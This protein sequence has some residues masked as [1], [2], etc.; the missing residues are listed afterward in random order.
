MTALE[1]AL[2]HLRRHRGLARVGSFAPTGDWAVVDIDVPVSLPSRARASGRSASGVRN[3]ETCWLWFGPRWPMTAPLVRLRE[4]FPLNLPHINP[5]RAGEQVAPCLFEGDIGEVL[6]RFG[7]DA[8][9]DQLIDWLDKAAADA[10]I[11]LRQG[12]EP[13]RRDACPSSV[14]FSAEALVDVTPRDGTILPLAATFLALDDHLQSRVAPPFVSSENVVFGQT[15]HKN[16][17]FNWILGD[18]AT[19]VAR[20]ADRDGLPYIVGTY[21]PETVHDLPTLLDRAQAVG[22]DAEALAGRLQAYFARSVLQASTDPASWKDGVLA[23][24]I[25][26]V[27]RPAPLVGSSGRTAEVL[28]YAVRLHYDSAGPMVPRTEAHAAHHRHAL[29]PALLSQTSGL[30]GTTTALP[31]VFLGCGSLGSKVALHLGRAGFG[32]VALVDNDT[33]QPH[34]SARHALVEAQAIV[35]APR[36]ADLMATAFARLSHAGAKAFHH[37]AVD[38]LHSAPLF[39]SI[40]PANTVLL[41]DATASLTVLAAETLSASLDASDA[42]LFRIALYGQGHCA[43]GLL[44]S[45]ARAVRV[46]DLAAA[47]FDRCRSDDALRACMAGTSTEPTSLFIGDNCRSLTFP[48]ADSTVSRAAALFSAQIEEWL[49]KELPAN[50]QLCVGQADETGLG[51]RWQRWPIEPSVVLRVDADDG[52]TIRVL[53]SVAKSIASEVSQWLPRETG[54]ALLGRA[55]YTNRTIT[56]AG[57]VD[58]PSDSVRD[59][60]RFVLGVHGLHAALRTAHERSLGYLMFVGTWHSHPMGGSHSGIDRDTLH[61]IAQDAVGLPVVSLVWRPEGLTC[62]VDRW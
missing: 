35:N 12:W 26:V 2:H 9:V 20:A 15:Q 43:V 60:S 59:A 53:G 6:H 4:D 16:E 32:N 24:V 5:H 17:S 19:F 44:E 10:L 41:I 48:M 3:V 61:R 56:I 25:L 1:D 22:V 40:V 21:Q 8:I 50:A 31:L 58:A 29:S 54:G 45:A 62:E 46:D 28:P 11:D 18:A 39:D 30:K 52:W 23:I 36:K 14:T 13:T 38:V 34:N 37:D 55:C 7:L 51:M 27:E 42:R 33:L 49:S 47:L 57:V